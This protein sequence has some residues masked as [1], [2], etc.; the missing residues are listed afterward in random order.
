[1]SALK[2]LIIKKLVYSRFAS[3]QSIIFTCRLNL[4]ENLRGITLGFFLSRC[5]AKPNG[6]H[7]APGGAGAQTESQSDPVSRGLLTQQ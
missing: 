2:D 5:G 7:E 1:M 3:L 6:I 4:T